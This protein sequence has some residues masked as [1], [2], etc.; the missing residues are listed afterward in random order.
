M[1]RAR[2]PILARRGRPRPL[3]NDERT[4]SPTAAKWRMDFVPPLPRYGETIPSVS[5]HPVRQPS[6]RH[7]GVTS[8][9]ASIGAEPPAPPVTADDSKLAEVC[10]PG[11]AGGAGH[12][13]NAE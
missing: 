7:F 13:R 12:R 9:E 6:K 3:E 4:G 10:P 8:A 1:S 5:T 11:E 2:G